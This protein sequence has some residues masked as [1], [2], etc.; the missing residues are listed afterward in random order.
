MA[1]LVRGAGAIAT[2]VARSLAAAAATAVT[3]NEGAATVA[4]SV[5]RNAGRITRT[6]RTRAD[7]GTGE[8]MDSG[9][10]MDIGEMI[11]TGVKR[12]VVITGMIARNAARWVV[13][14]TTHVGLHHQSV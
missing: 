4:D 11:D 13:G 8:R 14:L 7:G 10:K 5:T 9:E 3:T 1:S 6:A 2:T 12:V